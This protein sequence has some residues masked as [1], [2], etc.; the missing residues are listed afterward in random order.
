L[1]DYQ[2]KM[3]KIKKGEII[4]LLIKRSR[5]GFIVIKITK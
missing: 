1:N 5:I 2:E 3:Q 4:H